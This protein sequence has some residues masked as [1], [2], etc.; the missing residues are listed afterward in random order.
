M[1]LHEK[2]NEFKEKIQVKKLL[3]QRKIE[4]KNEENMFNIG[5][6]RKKLQSM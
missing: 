3:G 4:D 1:S 6:F 5:R 2:C